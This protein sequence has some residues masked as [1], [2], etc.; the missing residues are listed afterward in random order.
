MESEKGVRY[1]LVKRGNFCELD[2]VEE[3]AELTVDDTPAQAIED[4]TEPIE[5]MVEEITLETRADRIRQ[6]QADVQRGIIEI[7]FELIAAKKEIGH[8]S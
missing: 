7:G 3:T 1:Q 6:L 8:G 4:D 2:F 5:L